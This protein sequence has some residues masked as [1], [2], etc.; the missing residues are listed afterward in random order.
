M[1]LPYPDCYPVCSCEPWQSGLILQPWAFW[2]SLFYLIS[3]WLVWKKNPRV[4]SA[5]VS[6]LLIVTV[7]SLLAHA[8]FDVWSLA[9]DEASVVVVL[10]SYHWKTSSPLKAFLLNLV[11]ILG[12]GTAFVFLPLP[13]WVPLVVVT[14][15]G[16]AFLAV[17]KRGIGMLRDKEFLAAMSI[18]VTAFVFFIFDRHPFICET[19]GIPFGHPLWHAGSA[20]TTFLLGDWWFRSHP[21]DGTSR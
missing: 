17:K 21:G 10:Y 19:K 9:F 18:Y 12:I 15:M 11:I 5:W 3:A 2:S 20:L 1:Q 13:L 4:T 14:F 8:S 16:S 7:A 6:S